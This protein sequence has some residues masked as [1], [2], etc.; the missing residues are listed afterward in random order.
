MRNI[1]KARLVLR[2]FSGNQNRLDLVFQR[3]LSEIYKSLYFKP[4]PLFNLSRYVKKILPPVKTENIDIESLL[5]NARENLRGV[6]HLSK[7]NWW[8]FWRLNEYQRHEFKNRLSYISQNQNLRLQSK[9]FHIHKATEEAMPNDLVFW[10]KADRQNYV[11]LQ[12]Q[13]RALCVTEAFVNGEIT[14]KVY[15][16]QLITYGEMGSHV[17]TIFRQKF[18]TELKDFERYQ[19]ES[20]KYR[21]DQHREAFKSAPQEENAKEGLAV[22]FKQLTDSPLKDV[23]QINSRVLAFN[24]AL[25]QSSFFAYR[26]KQEDIAPE[27]KTE[28]DTVFS[29]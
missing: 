3:A 18:S 25:N 23:I 28:A 22:D 7:P 5:E 27:N 6:A 24:S 21:A 15:I 8:E 16:S 19:Q 26:Q 17:A 20:W 13:A 4:E 12:K 29:Y 14:A 9:L 11:T 1:E 10:R 2:G